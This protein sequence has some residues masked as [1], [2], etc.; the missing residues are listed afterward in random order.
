MMRTFHSVFYKIRYLVYAECKDL[1]LL[2]K[3][4]DE[5]KLFTEFEE[6]IST[7]VSGEETLEEMRWK[8]LGQILE[9]CIDDKKPHLDEW[10]KRVVEMFTGKDD[11]ANLPYEFDEPYSPDSDE[12]PYY[13]KD[14]RKYFDAE[15]VKHVE[16]EAASVFKTVLNRIRYLVFTQCKDPVLYEKWIVVFEWY[17][18]FEEESKT[19]KMAPEVLDEIRW[20]ILR[21]TLD[22]CIGD[23]T[24]KSGWEKRVIDIFSGQDQGEDLDDEQPE[25]DAAYEQ[26][27][28]EEDDDYYSF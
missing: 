28:Y 3:L 5:F 9:T 17:D 11:G 18:V 14:L 1:V 16:D 10:E 19:K 27:E 20:A 7:K 26:H 12:I 2:R 4:W 24:N 25:K 13:E 15:D 22:V 21:Q 8:R 6:D 23:W